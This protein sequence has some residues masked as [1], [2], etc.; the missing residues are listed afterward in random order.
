MQWQTAPDLESVFSISLRL[1]DAEGD[2]VYQQDAVLENFETS[3]T[4]RWQA[5]EPVETLHFLA[6]PSD[7]SPGE[8]E[9]RLVVYDF[10]S[11]KPTVELG[12]WEA[13]KTLT[14]MKVGERE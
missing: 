1:H 4:N 5:E 2:V 6:F 13:E 7:L 9:L 12:V 8:Y 3:T 14:R 10:E 11:Q